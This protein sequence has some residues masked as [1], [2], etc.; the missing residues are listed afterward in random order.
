MATGNIAGRFAEGIA[1]SNTGELAAVSSRSLESAQAFANK[2]GG[3]AA[4]GSHAELLA[5]DEIDAV[6]IASPHPFHAEM[7]IAAA[8]AG[9]HILCEKPIAMNMEEAEAIIAAAQEAGVV[10]V[11]AYMYRCH[12][13]TA[14][15]AQLLRE[16]AI[17]EIKLVQ[18]AFG[19]RAPYDPQGRLFAKELGGGGIL[20]VGGYTASFA[21]MVADIANGGEETQ[22]TCSGG[23]G[24]IDAQCGTDTLALANL[25]FSNGVRAQL[26]C[27]TQ[28]AQDNHVRIYGS[29]G[30]IDI[31]EAWIVSPLGGDWS[32]D[33]H[34]ADEQTPEIISGH[35][36]RELYGVEA[37]TF[38]QLVAGDEPEAPYMRISDTRRVNQILADWLQQL[39]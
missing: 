14:K 6:Y 35:E 36:S 15:V 22:V 1:S 4:Y 23:T 8:R 38:A 5:Q 16:G 24:Q 2:F 11:E 7:A 18:A 19:F 28:L 9:K 17:G 37:D 25:T 34:R 26:S 30:W 3:G 21:C 12:P 32:F 33:L 27:S 29:K 13:Q 10:L 39:G 20:D 31:S